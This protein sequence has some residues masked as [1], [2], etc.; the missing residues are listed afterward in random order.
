[1]RFGAI[2]LSGLGLLSRGRARGEGDVRI[3]AARTTHACRPIETTGEWKA[4]AMDIL[5]LAAGFGYFA[6]MFGFV[7]I[8]EKL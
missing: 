4:K 1:M 3:L 7:R 5:L 6:L 2:F 8:C